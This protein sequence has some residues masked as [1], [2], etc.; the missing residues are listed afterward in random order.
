MPIQEL[1]WTLL[2]VY[3]STHCIWLRMKPHLSVKSIYCIII[4]K[5]CFQSSFLNGKSGLD[6]RRTPIVA[7]NH[8]WWS[9]NNINDLE[10][11]ENYKLALDFCTEYPETKIKKAIRSGSF[12]GS[13]ST[14]FS[15]P[16]LTTI[17][18]NTI[19]EFATWGAGPGAHC[20]GARGPPKW[21]KG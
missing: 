16:L 12:F 8:R 17:S 9:I 7:L 14:D 10:R 15:T 11:K 18:R 6:S 1:Y 19:G 20:I 13:P 4:H 3:C 5:Q 21:H 2:W